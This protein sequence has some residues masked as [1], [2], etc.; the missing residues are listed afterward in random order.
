M[1]EGASVEVSRPGYESSSVMGTPSAGMS[2][3]G[4]AAEAA[5]LAEAMAARM[6]EA[7]MLTMALG[8][9]ADKGVSS[10]CQQES[11]Q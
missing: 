2:V 11:S 3:A 10:N 1:S 7:L 6:A 8:D 4:M 9:G 5:S